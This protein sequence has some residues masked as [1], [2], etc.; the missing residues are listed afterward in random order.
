MNPK[1]ELQ[2]LYQKRGWGLPVY[3]H[4]T[5]A[6][7]N[8]LKHKAFIIPRKTGIYHPKFESNFHSTKREAEFEVAKRVI[9]CIGSVIHKIEKK[10]LGGYVTS[11]KIDQWINSNYD[12]FCI[13]FIIP[14]DS[15]K[16]KYYLTA[17][18][19]HSDNIENEAKKK[20][21]KFTGNQF[22]MTYSGLKVVG[23]DVI[24]LYASSKCFGVIKT[25]KNPKCGQITLAK[26]GIVN[27][28]NLQKIAFKN[29]FHKYVMNCGTL[30]LE[31]SMELGEFLESFIGAVYL[32]FGVETAFTFIK[33]LGL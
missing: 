3:E 4:V 7:E 29:G 15:F 16:V 11:D 1:N 19:L 13:D 20:L 32:L 27:R 2:E 17:A 8:E 21:E 12:Q 25:Y 31:T 33:N 22:L 24:G 26:T 10:K 5:L 9:N 18:F 6:I 28:E 23:D 14:R 30:N